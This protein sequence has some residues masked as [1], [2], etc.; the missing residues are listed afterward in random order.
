MALEEAVHF[1]KKYANFGEKI[2]LRRPNGVEKQY[3]FYCRQCRRP[4]EGSGGLRWVASQDCA[5]EAGSLE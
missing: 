1:H 5:F 3:R 4:L 2:L